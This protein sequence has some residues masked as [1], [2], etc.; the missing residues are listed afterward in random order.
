MAETALYKQL[1]DYNRT[2]TNNYKD[3]WGSL[4]SFLSSKDAKEL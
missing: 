4:L 2:I 1:D 3:N